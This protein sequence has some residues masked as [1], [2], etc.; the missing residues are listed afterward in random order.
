MRVELDCPCRASI[1]LTTELGD[2]KSDDLASMT[3]KARVEKLASEWIAAHKDHTR[4]AP[5][6]RP[7]Q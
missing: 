6:G 2:D 4:P 7:T 1:V 5:T 3:S